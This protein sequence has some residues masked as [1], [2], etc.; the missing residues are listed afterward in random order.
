MTWK[1]ISLLTRNVITLPKLLQNQ[2]LLGILNALYI[3]HTEPISAQ[4]VRVYH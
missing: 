1:Q 4:R 3:V 2:E